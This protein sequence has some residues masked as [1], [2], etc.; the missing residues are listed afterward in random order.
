MGHYKST[1]PPYWFDDFEPDDDDPPRPYDRRT[2]PQGVSGK[3]WDIVAD[4]LEGEAPPKGEAE[5]APAE[6]QDIEDT[7]RIDVE[8]IRR[9]QNLQK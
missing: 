5:T 2:T 1:P 4:A 6:G 7:Q 9:A 3:G 8:A